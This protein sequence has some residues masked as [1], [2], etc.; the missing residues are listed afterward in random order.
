MPG[1]TAEFRMP[2]VL[3]SRFVLFTKLTMAAFDAK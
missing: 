1:V 3:R 2:N